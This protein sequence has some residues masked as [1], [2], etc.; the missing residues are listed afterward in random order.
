MISTNIYTDGEIIEVY[1]MKTGYIIKSKIVNS[2]GLLFTVLYFRV[3]SDQN[4][5]HISVALYFLFRCHNP[6]DNM[7]HHSP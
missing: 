1:T 6:T 7:Q 4:V 5:E 2:G 3:I